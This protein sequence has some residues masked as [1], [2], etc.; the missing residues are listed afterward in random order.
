[1]SWAVAAF[2]VASLVLSLCTAPAAFSEEPAAA[3]PSEA[4]AVAEEASVSSRR[5]IVT[6]AQSGNKAGD[7]ASLYRLIDTL[8]DFPGKDEVN[9]RVISEGK[10]I[11]LKLSDM[12]ADYCPQLHQRLME[13]VGEDGIRLEATDSA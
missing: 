13:I 2:G 4:P 11:K 9:L 7:I 12:Y 6:I 8:K 10:T 5:L 1:M 3:E